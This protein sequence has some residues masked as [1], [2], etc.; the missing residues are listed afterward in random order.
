MSRRSEAAYLVDMYQAARDVVRFAGDCSFETYCSD[1]MRRAA[2]ERRVTIIGEAANKVSAETQE[3]HPQIEWRRI[4]SLRHRLVHDYPNIVH[5]RMWR[6][7][8]LHIPE[9]IRLLEPIVDSAPDPGSS[10]TE[11]E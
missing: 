9:L 11:Q 3:K 2:V 7:V 4:V 5:E 10:E 6:V 8:T 1:S